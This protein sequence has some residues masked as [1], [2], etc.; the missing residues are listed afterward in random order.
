VAA[1]GL[2]TILSNGGTTINAEIAESAETLDAAP[3]PGTERGVVGT[4][5]R[6]TND[7]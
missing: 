2:Y 1:R 7:S 4:S 5:D 3:Q 6:E